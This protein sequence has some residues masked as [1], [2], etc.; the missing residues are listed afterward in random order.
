MK[1]QEKI[2]NEEQNK[3]PI[4]TKPFREPIIALVFGILAVAIPWVVGG[5]GFLGIVGIIISIVANQKQKTTMATIALIL[6]IIGLALAIFSA[7][8][9]SL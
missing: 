4:N 8:L 2:N 9:N 5:G 6:S 3:I 7:A 1:N